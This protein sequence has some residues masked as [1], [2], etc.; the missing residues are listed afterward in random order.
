MGGGSDSGSTCAGGTSAGGSVALEEHSTTQSPTYLL[1]Y[2]EGATREATQIKYSLIRSKLGSP[3]FLK[4]GHSK[5]KQR[6]YVPESNQHEYDTKNNR[7]GQ[8]IKQPYQSREPATCFS[9][10]N[11]FNT[12]QQDRGNDKRMNLVFSFEKKKIIEN[13]KR[14]K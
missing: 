13:L 7:L 12:A 11:E 10:R 8:R 3:T 14:Q 1:T 2:F 4:N 9:K 6:R 5:R